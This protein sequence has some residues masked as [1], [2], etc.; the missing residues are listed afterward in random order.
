MQTKIIIID[1]HT[2]IR[3]A[4]AQV[5]DSYPSYTVVAT[6]GSAEE[7]IET[8]RTQKPDI[9]I[10]D[11]NLPGMNGIEATLV[12]R[13]FLPGI[14]IIGVSLHTQ[15]AYAK[16]MMK[17][18]AQAYVTKSS[19]SQEMLAALEAVKKG[20]NY[21]C[22]EIKDTIAENFTSTDE[23][24]TQHVLSSREIE[25]IK[26]LKEGLCSR[27]V[28]AALNISSKTVEVH[29]YNILRKLK[30]KNVAALISYANK[31]AIV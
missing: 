26:R 8:A 15:P 29:R 4:W 3:E 2:L 5:I 31:Y 12:L 19:G 17:N 24:Q 16:Q 18:G 13:K 28:G 22:K 1:D 20:N 10:M 30:L 14:K 11:I 27:E 7:G 23:E 9:I 21:I 6:Y 25:I